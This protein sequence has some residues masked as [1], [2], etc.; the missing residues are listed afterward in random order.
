MAQTKQ[1]HGCLVIKNSGANVVTA[2]TWKNRRRKFAAW[3]KLTGKSFIIR[4][5]RSKKTSGALVEN[6][7][8]I[9]G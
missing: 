7:S 9:V 1:K 8:Y 3:T 4:A 2:L 6:K 5:V